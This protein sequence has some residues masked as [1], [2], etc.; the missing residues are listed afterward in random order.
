VGQLGEDLTLYRVL[1]SLVHTLVEMCQDE[2]DGALSAL[3][4]RHPVVGG[5]ILLAVSALSALSVVSVVRVVKIILRGFPRAPGGYP[6]GRAWERVRVLTRDGGSQGGN[7][8]TNE[9]GCKVM[10]G[11]DT[12]IVHTRVPD[13]RRLKAT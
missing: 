13:R 7:I 11:W 3:L 4:L 2:A 12:V 10:N 1:Q 6:W 5:V 9:R 8:N